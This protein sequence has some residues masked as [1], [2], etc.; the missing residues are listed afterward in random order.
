LKFLLDE[1]LII[2]TCNRTEIYFKSKN[3][4]ENIVELIFK[5]M[6][7]DKKLEKYIYHLLDR[8]AVEHAM[9]LVC[10]FQS[11]VIGEEQILSQFKQSYRSSLNAKSIKSEFSSLFKKAIKCGKEFRYNSELYRIPVS[12]SSIAV[13]EAKRRKAKRYMILGYGD[14][15]K[16][17]LKYILSSDFE[18]VYIVVPD[19]FQEEINHPKVELINFSERRKYYS[20][21]DCIISSTSAPHPL[22]EYE[23][24]L[25]GK[26]IFDLAVPRDVGES[27]YLSHETEVYNID[28]L[29]KVDRENQEK[30]KRIMEEN[31][32][33]VEKYI[34][35]FYDWKTTK[36]L[37]PL[38]IEIKN[39][40]EQIVDSRHETFKNK[41]ETKDVDELAYT[42]IKS[43]SNAYV[44]RA[45]DLLKS[46]SLEGRGEECLDIIKKIFCDN[47]KL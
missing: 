32:Y 5:E 36:E 14:V 4:K 40:A 46:K 42:L 33:I 22:I 8:E 19:D 25:K 13:S 23:D 24:S 47:Q 45:I 1:V 27:V 41:R 18:K 21:V 43:T 38:I 35:E 20:I 15:G 2:S 9:Y 16:L 44:N 30:R 3:K 17:T 11:V 31:S 39:T 7:W 28:M 34:K 29:R 6:N 10:G 12:S 26:L 37:T